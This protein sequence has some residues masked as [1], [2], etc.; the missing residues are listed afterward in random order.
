M[1]MMISHQMRHGRH[2]NHATNHVRCTKTSKA[3]Q[4]RELGNIRGVGWRLQAEILLSWLAQQA[5]WTQISIVI[6]Y[7]YGKGSHA[8]SEGPL[9]YGPEAGQRVSGDSQHTILQTLSGPSERREGA[10]AV[11]R[12]IASIS[13][14]S[15]TV[16][17]KSD[18]S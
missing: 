1:M 17:A 3:G 2:D 9:A 7:H 10:S 16:L 11:A 4:K 8:V 13:K 6:T 18:L 15:H 5:F 14:S 12:L